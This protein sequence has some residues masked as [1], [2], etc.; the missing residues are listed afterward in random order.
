MLAVLKVAAGLVAGASVLTL[1]APVVGE[2]IATLPPFFPSAAA[3][4]L[5]D[6][7]LSYEDVEFPTS[8]GLVLRGWFVPAE[9]PDAPAVLYA[10]A[11]A[12]DQ[13]S[14]L[15]LVPELRRSG[16]HSLLFSYRGH[17]ISDGARGKFT[18]GSSESLDVD[19]AVR[20]LSETRGIDKIAVIGHSAGAVSGIL[21][22]ARNAAV[23]AVVAVAP[24]TCIDDIWQ[25]NKPAL[26]PRAVLN[27]TLRLSEKWRGFSRSEVCPVEVI[28][29]I[30]PRPLLLIHGLEDK[31]ITE[32]QAREIFEAA[33]EPKSLW[34]VEGATHS[35]I[36]EHALDALIP[37]VVTFLNRALRPPAGHIPG[38]PHPQ[39]ARF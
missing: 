28:D 31:R 7:D 36:R 25:T 5:D 26:V 11:T 10:P 23:G 37:Q 29:R 4:A 33:R 19:A 9:N 12:H 3:T 6:L 39:P 1:L 32:D 30:A 21:S 18:Y 2:A 38:Q 27:W 34:L 15:S 17:G 13:R 24:F 14:G 8:D 35:G 16:F 20:Y 22:G